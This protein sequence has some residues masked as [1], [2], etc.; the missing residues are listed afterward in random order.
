MGFRFNLLL[1]QVAFTGHGKPARRRDDQMNFR[2]ATGS[3]QVENF[4]TVQRTAGTCDGH[5]DGLF[6]LGGEGAA[7]D[8]VPEGGRTSIRAT[9][10][11][12]YSDLVDALA[13]AI[14]ACSSP[15]WYI[16]VMMSQPPK[17]S[18]FT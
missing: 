18:P 1:A 5:S 11:T 17:N 12:I 16:S 14:N 8:G 3:E 6:E 15:L 10:F 4:Q 13:A 9:S 2:V 7:Q